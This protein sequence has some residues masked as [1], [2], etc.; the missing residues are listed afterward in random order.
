MLNFTINIQKR[1]LHH[2]FQ[3]EKFCTHSNSELVSI[4]AEAGTT[5]GP[6]AMAPLNF[7]KKYYYICVLI[8]AI[9]F[10]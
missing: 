9:F 1:P 5:I 8:L 10:Y 7:F 6:G 3:M 4:H 2:R